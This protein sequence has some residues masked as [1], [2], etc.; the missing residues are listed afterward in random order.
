MSNFNLKAFTFIEMLLSLLITLLVLSLIP[1]MLKLTHFYLHESYEN[2][3]T[4]Y[5]FFL[6]DVSHLSNKSNTSF[7]IINKNT[8]LVQEKE[9]KGY[10][11]Y[12]N[13][14]LIYENNGRGN[15]TLLNN[16][17][18]FKTK[19]INSKII[20]VTLKIGDETINYEKEFYI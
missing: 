16:V 3:Q 10:I 4:E 8:I 11:K 7:Q 13:S 1:Q 6:S 19:S 12:K 5:T 14:K 9:G 18:D 2:Y 20:K 15:I 17:I